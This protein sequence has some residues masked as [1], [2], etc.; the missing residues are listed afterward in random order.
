MKKTKFIS[1]EQETLQ[2]WKICPP[3][4]FF[5]FPVRVASV[6]DTRKGRREGVDWI[7][8][9]LPGNKTRNL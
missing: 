6:C 4:P 5:E 3:L 2:H 9:E 7:I 1:Q 8:I